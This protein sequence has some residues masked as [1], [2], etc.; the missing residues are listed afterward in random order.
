MFNLYIFEFEQKRISLSHIRLNFNYSNIIIIFCQF[1]IYLRNNSCLL[2]RN[3]L[4][5]Y[6]NCF[7][8]NFIKSIKRLFLLELIYIIILYYSWILCLNFY[9]MQILVYTIVSEFFESSVLPNRIWLIFFVI[10]LKL[11]WLWTIIELSLVYLCRNF[12][13]IYLT[14]LSN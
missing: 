1:N 5:R 11:I 9:K 2:Y 6:R 7:C 12:V 3:R 14:M 4:F 13:K 8:F 10:S